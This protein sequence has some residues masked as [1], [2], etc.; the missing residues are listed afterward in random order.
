MLIDDIRN[1][2]AAPNSAEAKPF[3]ERVDSTL[4][5]GYAHALQLEAE[6]WRIEQRIAEL[7]AA[8]PSETSE[9]RASELSE[10]SQRLASANESIASLRALLDS[11]RERR[12]ELRNAA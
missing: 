8:L 10:L 7:L 2:L 5:E 12:S 4:T 6:R 9:L 11:L 1:L 3:L